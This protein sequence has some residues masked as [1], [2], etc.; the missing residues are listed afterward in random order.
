MERIPPRAS[1]QRPDLE[2]GLT[3]PKVPLKRGGIQRSVAG[4]GAGLG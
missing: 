1:E 4:M 3:E 2:K